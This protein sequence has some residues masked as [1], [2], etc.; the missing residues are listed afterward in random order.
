[1]A[2]PPSLQN[3]PALVLRTGA[4]GGLVAHLTARLIQVWRQRPPSITALTGKQIFHWRR[5]IPAVAMSNRH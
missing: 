1:M 5:D 2:M 4:G 3:L